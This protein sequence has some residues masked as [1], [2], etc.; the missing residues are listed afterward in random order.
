MNRK[1]LLGVELEELFL[2]LVFIII[3][4]IIMSA[5]IHKLNK[6]N[7]QPI[8][9]LTR[10]FIDNNELLVSL[11]NP[12][13]LSHYQGYV[14][15][16]IMKEIIEGKSEIRVGKKSRSEKFIYTDTEYCVKISKKRYACIP[17][18]MGE[19]DYAYIK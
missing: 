10:N 15:T 8:K 16:D 5:T 18:K 12:A 7:S 4:G 13:E 14:I 11:K 9:E 6:N 3:S 17:K 2:L 1:S 19:F